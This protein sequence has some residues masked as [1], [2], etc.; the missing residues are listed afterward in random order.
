MHYS[1]V[2][3]WL[4][5]IPSQTIASPA[6]KKRPFIS[7]PMST[8][9]T[10]SR[11]RQRRR[12]RTET[13]DRDEDIDSNIDI[14]DATPR[15]IRRP[16]SSLT[17]SGTSSSA[18]SAGGSSPRKQLH[19]LRLGHD[20]VETRTLD[21]EGDDTLPAS[22]AVILGDIN[23]ATNRQRKL[24]PL[25]MRQQASDFFAGKPG[26][27]QWDDDTLYDSSRDEL[28]PT[29][30]LEI[31]HAIVLR[32]RD[33]D[34]D[35]LDENGWSQLVY[36]HI[37]DGVAKDTPLL[38]LVPCSSASILSLYKIPA[39]P[40]RM[41]DYVFAI[42]P[43]PADRTKMRELIADTYGLSINHT[44]FPA[45][46]ERPIALSI[47]VKRT[48]DGA[49]KA[50]LQLAVWLAAHWKKL[51][52]MAG[53]EL[54]EFLLAVWI[55]GHDWS[56]VVSTRNEQNT[57]IWTKLDFGHTRSSTGHGFSSIAW[58]WP[59]DEDCRRS[60]DTTQTYVGRHDQ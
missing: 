43:I 31:V 30:S 36:W 15:Q 56:L 6:S 10:P 12:D 59:R 9:S 40:S 46:C 20:G 50:K 22:L 37:L 55:Q 44:S 11:K 47:E 54:P 27:Q 26:A 18:Q 32:A 53:S 52:H 7:P 60:V 24:L 38:K 28:G 19:N 49:D 4:A 34:D 57:I 2:S 16:A 29:P 5:Q 45:L 58:M 17:A 21:I 14:E 39:T 1:K 13:D 33:C 35:S 25:I 42:D 48:S 51:R 8:A 3:D 41:V 23:K